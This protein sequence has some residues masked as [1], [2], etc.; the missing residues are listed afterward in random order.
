MTNKEFDPKTN[1]KAPQPQAPTNGQHSSE[2]DFAA[3]CAAEIAQIRG[4]VDAALSGTAQGIQAILDDYNRAAAPLVDQASL[5]L[6]NALSGRRA[7]RAI[8]VNVGELMAQ[9]PTGPKQ[10][11]SVQPLKP[12]SFKPLSQATRQNYLTGSDVPSNTASQG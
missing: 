6:Y 4:Q 10:M 3:E 7:F 5:E 9:H 2:D 12:V 11:I 8:G 1:P